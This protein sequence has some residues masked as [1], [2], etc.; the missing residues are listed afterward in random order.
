MPIEPRTSDEIDTEI[1]GELLSR[2]DA[3]T[4]IEPGG[5]N[6]VFLSAHSGPIREAELKALAAE[7]AGYVEFAGKELSQDDLDA[8][9]IEG[10][11]PSEINPYMAD[12]QLDSLAA[13]FGVQRDPGAV[14]EGEVTFEVV[15]DGVQ[16]EEGTVVSTS[17]RSGEDR[18][19]F[20]VD[21]DGDGE[22]TTDPAPTTTADAGETSVTVPVVATE[23]GTEYNVAG[24]EITRIPVPRPGV[25]SVE[26]TQAITGGE[27][28]QSNSSL[29]SDVQSALVRE[30][31]GGTR[32]GI[33][34]YIES[35]SS[36]E[37]SSV[38]I[39]EFTDR[40][41]PFVDVVID[42]GNESEL[43]Q[44]IDESKPV[45]IRH[46]LV[47]PTTVRVGVQGGVLV[48]ADIDASS[49]QS[50]LL[51]RLSSFNVGD[52]FYRS[53]FLGVLLNA[54]ANVVS[55]PVLNTTF[56]SVSR[57]QQEY[58]SGQSIYD[59]DYGPFGEVDSENHVIAPNKTIFELAYDDVDASTVSVQTIQDREQ[60]PVPGSAVSVIDTNGDG[61]NDAIE[62]T[63]SSYLEE[64]TVLEVSYQHN[65]WG[66]S[67][68]EF[69]DGTTVDPDTAVN[70]ID[71][72]GDGINDAIEWTGN[73][74]TPA[75]GERFFISYEPRRE[76]SSDVRVGETVLFDAADGLVTVDWYRSE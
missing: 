11:E 3:I 19:D 29:R 25:Q 52:N 16:I 59:L 46:N 6:D 24:G 34:G 5:F 38:G 31:G 32:Q 22:I 40:D 74:A 14:A 75:D 57:E 43:R 48:D 20:V 55:G 36:E 41:P 73:T 65:T 63:D 71:D 17:L 18:R 37:I 49:I 27:D 61:L 15:D 8:L 56:E 64:K 7:L 23:A 33:Q 68:I 45:G 50:I 35:N 58:V 54:N 66:V 53:Q 76:F 1:R 2:I 67:A 72:D 47:R 12:E 70:I 26:N 39:N 30:S 10:V 4:Q 62:I 13:N 44:L 51:Q 42:G 60:E 21:V 28:P 9:G 69:E